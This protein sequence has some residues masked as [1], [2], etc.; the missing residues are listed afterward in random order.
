MGEGIRR[1]GNGWTVKK[2]S[3]KK[4]DIRIVCAVCTDEVKMIFC[5]L[6][7]QVKDNCISLEV[8]LIS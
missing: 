4:K 6:F 5:S 8:S 2:K 3:K 7:E 1:G